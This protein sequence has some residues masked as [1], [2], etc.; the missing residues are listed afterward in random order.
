MAE[1]KKSQ[2]AKLI[3]SPDAVSYFTGATVLKDK[4]TG[5]KV[6][7]FRGNRYYLEIDNP[8]GADKQGKLK[9]E[10]AVTAGSK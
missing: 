7:E 8:Y 1:S 4:M 9:V 3:F 5:G 6:D 10:I 2:N